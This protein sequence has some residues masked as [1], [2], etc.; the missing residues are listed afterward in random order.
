MSNRTEQLSS[1]QILSQN[2]LPPRDQWGHNY[3]KYQLI[4]NLYLL[5][6][7]GTL[8]GNIIAGKQSRK[9]TKSSKQ[10]TSPCLGA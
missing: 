3:G 10:K 9:K 5:K 4:E 8:D 2:D 1:G 7:F 6:K